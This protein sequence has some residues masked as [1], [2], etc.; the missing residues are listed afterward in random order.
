MQWMSLPPDEKFDLEK[1][2]NGHCTILHVGKEKILFIG[3]AWV[4]PMEQKVFHHFSEV[5]CVDTL[6]HNNKDKHPLLTISSRD[7]GCQVLDRTKLD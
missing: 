1:C 7:V 3:L 6:S 4:L 5:I 2:V